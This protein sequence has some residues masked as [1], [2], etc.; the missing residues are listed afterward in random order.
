[1]N[2]F[3]HWLE[4]LRTAPLFGLGQKFSDD[5]AKLLAAEQFAAAGEF[6]TAL[7][8]ARNLTLAFQ[9]P[10]PFWQYPWRQWQIRPLI[11]RLNDRVPSWRKIVSDYY[12]VFR[13][14][15]SMAIAGDFA[16]AESEL[17]SILTVY[18]HPDGRDLLKELQRLRQGQEWLKLGLAAELSGSLEIARYHY[19]NLANEF[20]QLQAICQRR[21]IVMAIHE[22]NW[23]AVIASTHNSSDRLAVK[24]NALARYQ[25]NQ[26][27]RLQLL[28]QIQQQ[29]QAQQ[30]EAA[31]QTSISY[32]EAMGTDAFI[33]QIRTEYIQPQLT[34][35]AS[36]WSD[37]YELGKQR[38]QQ[39]GGNALLHDWAIAAYYRF[40]S[41]LDRLD[42]LQELIPIWVTASINTNLPDPA[43]A[44]ARI[45]DLISSIV[46]R[47][48]DPT[49]KSELQL[50][51]QR[52]LM[53]VEWFGTPPTTG[54][55]IRGVFISPG[56]YDLFKSQMAHVQLPEKLW[57]MLY[58]P[59]WRSVVTCQQGNPVRAMVYK[60]T[61]PPDSVASQLAQKFVA[62]HEGCYYLECRPGGFPRWREAFRVLELAKVQILQSPTWQSTIDRLCDTHQLSIWNPAD[63]LEFANC[64]YDLLQS[65]SANIF[66]NF[67]TNSTNDG[68][69][70]S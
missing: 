31:W 62:Y 44:T 51:W 58:T 23:T 15:R 12:V 46:D 22:R 39:T 55:R 53:A 66:L 30:I 18:P 60:P 10:V 21:S 68:S 9:A 19:Q 17:N 38:W 24:Y 5:R 36:N 26:I 32:I 54:L 47:F 3:E 45:R 27:Q 11:A 16:K 8:V 28:R 29:L 20:P 48:P 33:Q 6:N 50:E 65:D 2:I 1:M 25:Q 59:W 4:A 35:V 61:D 40:G 41:N 14:A 34:N 37:R 57:A 63:R 42:W 70:S 69:Q 67:V 56:F 49:V 64:W 7:N 43:A 13:S 52:E